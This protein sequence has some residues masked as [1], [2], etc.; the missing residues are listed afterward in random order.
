MEAI[1]WCL[2]GL[3]IRSTSRGPPDVAR[4]TNTGEKMKKYQVSIQFSNGYCFSRDETG[5]LTI[6]DPQ[7]QKRR[8]SIKN[9]QLAVETL[10]G[11]NAKNFARICLLH[12]DNLLSFSGTSDAFQDAFIQDIICVNFK[13]FTTKLT[14]AGRKMK[15]QLKINHDT[16]MRTEEQLIHATKEKETTLR[17]LSLLQIEQ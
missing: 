11:V 8:L 5:F 3:I 7:Q 17:T 15:P 4:R 13:P 6:I 10:L 14:D 9:S 2:F 1:Y 16:M 12:R